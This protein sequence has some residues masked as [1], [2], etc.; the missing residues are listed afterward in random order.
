MGDEE[1]FIS[2]Y[3]Y[4][5][6]LSNAQSGGFHTYELAHIILKLNSL[7]SQRDRLTLIGGM[8]YSLLYNKYTGP[9]QS[10]ARVNKA[11]ALALQ[12]CVNESEIWEVPLEVWNQ[13]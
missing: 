1:V 8:W 3:Q 13:R 11:A 6:V 4:C 7:Q 12:E 10:N 2:L 9:L 5:K